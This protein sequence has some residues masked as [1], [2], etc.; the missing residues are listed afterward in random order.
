[1]SCRVSKEESSDLLART[2]PACRS[3]TTRCFPLLRHD[4]LCEQSA[5][6]LVD[7]PAPSRPRT[8][9]LPAAPA[10]ST[11]RLAPE[12]SPPATAA[13]LSIHRSTTHKT[14]ESPHPSF[15]EHLRRGS[16][17]RTC[18]TT[19][20]R[21]IL[22]HARHTHRGAPG[23]R[24]PHRGAS[25][26]TRRAHRQ[27]GFATPRPEP[28]HSVFTLSASRFGSGAVPSWPRPRELPT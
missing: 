24:F 23:R 9:Q 27:T 7:F 3:A 19:T 12:H 28:A 5:A 16:A 20:E 14:K 8:A 15:D 17:C 26:A 18:S 2:L 25:T 4:L 6:P 22:R 10:T 11:C 1:V 21:R 13:F